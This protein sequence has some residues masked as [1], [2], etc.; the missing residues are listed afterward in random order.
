MGKPTARE[1][2]TATRK[3]KARKRHDAAAR[4]DLAPVPSPP[5]PAPP[6]APEAPAAARLAFPIAAGIL[7]L[8]CALFVLAPL[9]DYDL[10]WH[11][12]VGQWMVEHG[13]FYDTE[14]FTFPLEGQAVVNKWGWL[15]EIILYAV[16]SFGEIWGGG[17]WALFGL[18]MALVGFIVWRLWAIGVRRFARSPFWVAVVL[19]AAL[20]LAGGCWWMRPYLLQYA[21]AI[22]SL[23][24]LIAAK[25]TGR[26][27]LLAW[28][29]LLQVVA[30]NTNQSGLVCLA[31]T[32][33]FFGGEV[34]ESLPER[35]WRKREHQRRIASFAITAAATLA[36]SGVN[37]VGLRVLNLFTYTQPGS[38]PWH[39]IGTFKI[40]EWMSPFSEEAIASGL[41]LLL[42]GFV[43][44]VAA[45]ILWRIQDAPVTYLLLVAAAA[46][47][48]LKNVRHSL[49]LATVGVAGV[50]AYLP[51]RAW[52]PKSLATAFVP[53]AVA[54]AGLWAH[55][56]YTALAYPA[57]SFREC[58]APRVIEARDAA[59][60]LAAAH[61]DARV[62]NTMGLGGALTWF[63]GNRLENF[64]DGRLISPQNLEEHN[65]IYYGPPS[66]RQ[67][68]LQKYAID[69]LFLDVLP[70]SAAGET[71]IHSELAYGPDALEK[72]EPVYR[73][74][75][76]VV[77]HAKQP[78]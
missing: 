73:G 16:H 67:A 36:A 6:E 59:R 28:V 12:S 1:A 71:L 69:T 8:S 26:W 44:A 10:W 32:G 61:P 62:F 4:R 14:V 58:L 20:F 27:R 76:V 39:A 34:L 50:M 70:E 22:V 30:I 37:P 2:R 52:Q 19:V 45:Y 35:R 46:Y 24:L 77:F 53:L 41:T 15:S 54:L 57:V 66:E 47:L 9:H 17:L 65:R 29:P 38:E 78:H 33:I 51:S 5:L 3:G 68:L 60:T 48:G 18:K 56:E 11:L 55:H 25:E 75:E 21:V 23:E 7:V 63:S 64:V 40:G 49:L 42:L 43:A 72:W 74:S 31:L 13:S